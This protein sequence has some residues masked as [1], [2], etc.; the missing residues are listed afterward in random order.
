M[1]Q[2]RS[3]G[4]DALTS[5]ER[6]IM[7]LYDN[8]STQAEICAALG[9]SASKVHRVV[10]MYSLGKIDRWMDDARLGSFDLLRALR[11]HHP[12]QIGAAQ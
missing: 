5:T 4:S 8:G 9:M 2:D 12:N 3:I 11:R 1:R 6:D 7:R 10:C